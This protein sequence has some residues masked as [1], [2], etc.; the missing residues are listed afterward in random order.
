M[1]KVLLFGFMCIAFLSCEK[2]DDGP[3]QFKP[4]PN[5]FEWQTGYNSINMVLGDTLR[6]FVVHVPDSY[7]EDIEF[8]LLMMFH[9]SSGDGDRFYKISGWVEKANEEGFIAVFPTALEYPIAD[10]K[11]WSTKWSGDGLEKDIQEGFPI[12]DDVNF[13]RDLLKVLDETFHLSKGSR[14]AV[15]FSGGGSFIRSRLM[16]EMPDAFAAFATG[17]G[18]GL[19]MPEVIP[20]GMERPLYCIVGSKDNHIIEA[21]G[22]WEEIALDP[23]AFMAQ[24]QFQGQLDAILST[25]KLSKVYTSEVFPPKKSILTFKEKLDIGAKEFKLMI[26]NELDHSFPNGKNNK[27][28]VSGPDDL[29]P[30]LIQFEI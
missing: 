10:S 5:A 29:W 8:P 21:S 13:I 7:S 3:G 12:K 24:S 2:I 11:S 27:F 16:S 17:G 15:G 26:V 18:F 30:W 28:N 20:Q 19:S 23:E 14:F 22:V 25:L 4:G 1:R 9:G 6:N